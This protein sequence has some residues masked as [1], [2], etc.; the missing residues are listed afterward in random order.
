MGE[1]KGLLFEGPEDPIPIPNPGLL[2]VLLKLLFPK[3]CP[4]PANGLLLVAPPSCGCG[5]LVG[6]PKG[7]W[8]C[9]MLLLLLLGGAPKGFELEVP[10]GPPGGADG[11]G[12][13]PKG[14][15][16]CGCGGGAKGLLLLALKPPNPAMIDAGNPSSRR[17]NNSRAL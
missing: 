4:A 11:G 9:I 3:V 14:P 17:H 15:C 12:K 8:G 1:A 5:V 7:P 16:P 6:C 2:L 13:V 10:K